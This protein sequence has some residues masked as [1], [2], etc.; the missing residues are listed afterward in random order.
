M[1]RRIFFILLI[2]SFGC[3]SPNKE[4]LTLSEIK[5]ISQ[6]MDN[7]SIMDSKLAFN[8][9]YTIGING[10][11]Y[12]L[13]LQQLHKIYEND[14]TREF[15][16][17]N[18]FAYDALNQRIKINYRDTTIGSNEFIR[19]FELMPDITNIYKTEGLKGLINKY[20]KQDEKRENYTLLEKV[21]YKN[22]NTISYYFFLNRY[23][24][25]ESDNIFKVTYTSFDK[26]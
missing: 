6:N 4:I 12:M 14:Y 8:M 10:S 9:V 1:K 20:C 19:R 25:T 15:V 3:S 2:V 5:R 21:E 13:N 7:N 17:F 16:N 26:W 18:Y 11:I 23:Y 22:V 24:T